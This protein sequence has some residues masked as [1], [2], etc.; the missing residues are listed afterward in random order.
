MFGGCRN[1]DSP[2]CRGVGVRIFVEDWGATYGSPYLVLS[3][4]GGTDGAVLAEDG[5]DLCCHPGRPY[6]P[7][8]GPIAFVDGVRRGEASLWLEDTRTGIGARGVAGGHACGAVI[9]DGVTRAI[10]G[11]TRVRRLAIWGSGLTGQL[12]AVAGGWSWE[13]RSIADSN[14]DAPLKDLQ[15][16]MRQEEGRLAEALCAEGYLTVVDGPLNFVR[17]RDLPVVGYVKTHYRALLDPEHHRRIPQLGSGERTSLFRL[18]QDRYSAYLRLAPIATTASPWTGIVRIEIPQS[19]GL[20]D[21]VAVADRIAG[22]LP[23]FAGIAHRDPRAP[24]NLQ[25]IG[26]VESHLRHLLGHPGLAT[27]A[28]REAVALLVTA[29]IEESL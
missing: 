12:P 17:S 16:R 20:A 11:E 1:S 2:G 28:V 18:G 26:A 19:A 6:Q 4:D 15:T 29:G 27:R 5:V 3:D 24:Q 23:Y 8:D 14:P 9:A 7:A 22:V 13:S 10:F 25:P 21:A